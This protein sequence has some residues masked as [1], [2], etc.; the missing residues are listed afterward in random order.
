MK[1]LINPFSESVA[2][3]SSSVTKVHFR[4]EQVTKE[5]QGIEISGVVMWSVKR[6]ED[7]PF[8]F[9]KYAGQDI[10]A[11]C[12]NLRMV[13]ESIVRNTVANSTISDVMSQRDIMRNMLKKGIMDA[14]QGWG[15]WVE[16]VE[17]TDV[18]ICSK[19]LFEDLQAEFRNS[20][21]L[22]A[23]RLKMQ[24][25][26]KV[27]E[28]RLASDQ[29]IA[30]QRLKSDQ[31]IAEKKAQTKADTQLFESRT[32]LRQ[33]EENAKLFAKQVRVGQCAKSKAF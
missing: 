10:D 20:A 25:T 4:A 17:L 33:E 23:Q 18:K 6:D 5:M 3:F 11:A 28:E 14:V 19:Q 13:T 26:Q 29:I 15:M 27:T 9:Y 30:E 32:K 1:T 12:D 22:N 2:K 8:R 31:L 21:H 7:G 16:T 24:T